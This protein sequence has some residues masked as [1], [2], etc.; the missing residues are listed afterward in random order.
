MEMADRR[1]FMETVGVAA[2]LAIQSAALRAKGQT[3]YRAGQEFCRL[4]CP[5][6]RL[7]RKPLFGVNDWNYD[8]GKK[9]AS[10]S[11]GTQTLSHHRAVVDIGCIQPGEQHPDGLAV[12]VSW[13]SRKDLRLVRCRGSFSLRRLH[14]RPMKGPIFALDLSSITLF[15]VRSNDG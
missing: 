7:P 4:M 1:D 10:A 6:P 15:G 8:Y 13:Q 12:L 3:I 14:W 2:V 9:T 5:T 11:S